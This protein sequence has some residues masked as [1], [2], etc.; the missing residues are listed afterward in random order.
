MTTKNLISDKLKLHQKNM[1]KLDQN[2]KKVYNKEK[3]TVLT[4]QMQNI[5]FN[6][7]KI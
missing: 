6:L 2:T 5:S 1:Y 7:S 3:D 4:F